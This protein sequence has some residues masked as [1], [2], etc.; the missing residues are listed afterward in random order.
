MIL[1]ATLPTVATAMDLPLAEDTI[2][3][4]PITAQD[5]I[6]TLDIPTTHQLA[7]VMGAHLRDHFWQAVTTFYLTKSKSS[8]KQ[9]KSP[10][11]KSSID[12]STRDQLLH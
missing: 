8:T 7:T 10:N 12:M 3:T 9:L 1:L 2:F 6:Q 5:L 4:L 11:S